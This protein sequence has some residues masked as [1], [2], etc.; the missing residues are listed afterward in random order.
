[1]CL[2]IIHTQQIIM[3]IRIKPEIP[4]TSPNIRCLVNSVF[5]GGSV[6]GR[7]VINMNINEWQVTR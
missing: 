4:S 2:A 3:V 5:E 6:A 7:S 1:M